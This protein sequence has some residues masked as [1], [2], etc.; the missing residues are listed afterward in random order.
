M[1]RAY[2]LGKDRL[3][4]RTFVFGRKM[5]FRR[6]TTDYQ[7]HPN[8]IYNEKILGVKIGRCI[9]YLQGK[10]IPLV[11]DDVGEGR[12]DLSTAEFGLDEA[13]YIMGKALKAIYIVIAAALS[14]I[15][16]VVGVMCLLK[17]FGMLEGAA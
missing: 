14:G 5:F 8:A 6:D 7:I 12:V 10:K 15:S 16:C 9:D 11:Y 13:A 1:I 3:W 4:H 2:I 17:L